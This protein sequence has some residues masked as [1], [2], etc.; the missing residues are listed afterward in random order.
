[1]TNWRKNIL[2]NKAIYLLLIFILLVAQTIKLHM[3]IEHENTPLTQTTIHTV[4]FHASPYL[5]ETN[6]DST[7]HNDEVHQHHNSIDIDV[8]V[9]TNN[10]VKKLQL[11]NPFVLFVFTLFVILC[12]PLLRQ[13]RGWNQQIKPRAYSHLSP[14]QRAPP[15]I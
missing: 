13:I 12:V 11:L 15:I 1:M 7:H 8:D 10:L 14:P 3:H 5:H 4:D 2:G 9:T 6:H